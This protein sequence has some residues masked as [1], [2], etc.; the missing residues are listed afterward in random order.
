M[1]KFCGWV[2]EVDFGV[3]D[4]FDGSDYIYEEVGIDEEF[5]L[6]GDVEFEDFEVIFYFL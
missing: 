3:D 5:E 6:E 1:L 2:E 4:S